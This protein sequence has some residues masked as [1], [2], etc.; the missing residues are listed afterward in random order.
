MK[1]R[2]DCKYTLGDNVAKMHPFNLQYKLFFCQV[3]SRS[4]FDQLHC[5]LSNNILQL[6]VCEPTAQLRQRPAVCLFFLDSSS[7]DVGMK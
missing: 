6:K 7:T 4:V 3:R 2:G 1:N 5:V